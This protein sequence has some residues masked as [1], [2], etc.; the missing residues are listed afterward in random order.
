MSEVPLYT[1]GGA[2]TETM[3]HVRGILLA[4]SFLRSSEER[5]ITSSDTR[6]KAIAT[7]ITPVALSINISSFISCH[8]I[9]ISLF[10]FMSFRF[11]LALFVVG[12]R[13]EERQ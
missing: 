1:K 12:D 11:Y 7:T 13:V 5:M 4:S 6:V 2:R 10:I 3:G 8:F 9:N